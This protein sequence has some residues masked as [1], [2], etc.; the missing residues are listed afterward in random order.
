MILIINHVVFVRR[1]LR[2]NIKKSRMMVS[3]RKEVEVHDFCTPYGSV[4][5]AFQRAGSRHMAGSVRH[6]CFIGY[7]YLPL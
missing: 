4:T 3:V 5:V 2:M 7:T 1:K 6:V